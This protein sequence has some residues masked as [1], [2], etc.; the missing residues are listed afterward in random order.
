MVLPSPVTVSADLLAALVV[1]EGIGELHKVLEPEPLWHAPADLDVRRAQVGELLMAH[2]WCDRDGR[3]DREVAASIAVLCRPD[4]EYYGWASHCG[5]SLGVLAARIGKEG[6]L[7]VA[8]AD[9]T[10]RLACIP[11]GQLA[12]RLVAQLPEVPAA[13]LDPFTVSTVDVRGRSRGGALVRRPSPEV[14]R[15][16]RLLERPTTGGGELS[17]ACR[18]RWG[19]RVRARVPLHYADTDLGRIASHVVDDVRVRV[20]PGTRVMLT[21]TLQALHPHKSGLDELAP[22]EGLR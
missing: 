1:A 21:V 4:E 17:V 13:R 19:R 2:G 20:Q 15:A 18:D 6:V 3:L 12:R 10:V 8:H 22:G 7:A 14:R 16:R 11:S 5:A 9:G